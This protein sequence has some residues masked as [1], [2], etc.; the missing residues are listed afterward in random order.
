MFGTCL[1]EQI[2]GLKL[3]HAQ[4][5]LVSD[6]YLK[7]NY[8]V[9]KRKRERK[10]QEIARRNMSQEQTKYNKK[11]VQKSQ[12]KLFGSYGGEILSSLNGWKKPERKKYHENLIGEK[13]YTCKKQRKT[14]F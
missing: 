14:G 6:Y 8:T 11:E 1:I 7:E 9:D 10:T 13:A 5:N 3:A 12:H 2:N 4:C